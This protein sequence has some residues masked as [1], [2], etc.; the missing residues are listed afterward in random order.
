MTEKKIKKIVASE[1]KKD[2]KKVKKTTDQIEATL[3]KELEGVVGEEEGNQIK[4]MP[5]IPLRG[6]SI[7]PYMVLH[8]DIGK[9]GRAHV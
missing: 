7:F 6:L 9:I 3:E 2:L 5:M 4:T 1:E 8:F